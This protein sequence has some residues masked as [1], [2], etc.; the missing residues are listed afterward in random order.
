[1]ASGSSVS[2]TYLLLVTVGAAAIALL[3]VFVLGKFRKTA[4]APRYRR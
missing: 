2:T 1:V 3:G 4:R